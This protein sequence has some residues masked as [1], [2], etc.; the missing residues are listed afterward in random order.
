[1][2]FQTKLKQFYG[3]VNKINSSFDK[4]CGLQPLQDIVLFAINTGH[5]I[6]E[7]T[8]QVRHVDVVQGEEGS[9]ETIVSF[10]RRKYD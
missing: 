10:W 6:I 2:I 1:M 3:N 8:S 9:D 7:P 4:A 5:A